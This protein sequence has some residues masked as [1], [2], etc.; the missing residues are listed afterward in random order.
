MKICVLVDLDLDGSE[1]PFKDLD[2]V[3]NPA[4]YLNGHVVETHS[5]TKTWGIQL[6]R[7]LATRDFDVFMNMCDGA[8][9][10]DRPGVEVVEALMEL[11]VAFTG[12]DV[13]FYNPSREEMKQVCHRYAI[14]TP[15][16]V[17]VYT[18]YELE[19]TVEHLRYPLI[20][21]HYNSYGSIGLGRDS[22]V[23]SFEELHHK[24]AEMLTAHQGALI[25]E[26]IEGREFSVLV[27]E[28]PDNPE[29]PVVFP[30]VEMVFPPGETFKH[31]ELKWVDYACLHVTPCMDEVLNTRLGQ[32]TRGLFL[33][34]GGRSY[35]R[36]DLRVDYQGRPYMLEINPN[37][38]VFLMPGQEG[39]ADHIL[40]YAPGQHAYFLDLILRSALKH[41]K[42]G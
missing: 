38:A 31:F 34:L 16:S 3:P 14:P 39:M 30:A 11:G 8:P 37:C 2:A 42:N 20:V 6:V 15:G 12:A 10:E 35:A 13:H 18:L 32:M 4:Y 7:E 33:G 41:R 23:R 17:S 19:K 9:D 28:N 24:T 40:K 1:S 29:L 27:A 25:E 22:R 21:K 36:C 5:L 26:F